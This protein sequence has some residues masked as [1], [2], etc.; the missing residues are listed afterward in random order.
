MKSNNKIMQ[1]NIIKMGNKKVGDNQPVFIIAEAGVNHN[2]SLKFAKK[3][4]DAAKESG[5]DAIKFQTYKTEELVIENAPMAVYQKRTAFGKS[6][7]QMLKQ[8]ELSEADFRELFNYCKKKKIIFLS[9]PFDLQSADFLF[10]L[11]VLAFKISSGDLTNIPLLNHIAK[12]G[13]PMIISTGMSTLAEVRDAVRAVNSTGNKKL[14][15]LHC[16]SNYPTMFEDVNSKA[17]V[18]LRKVFNVPVGY[19]DHT[20]GIEVCMSAVTMGACIIEKHVTL[21]KNLLG[22]DHKASL[23]LEELKKMV[24]CIRNIE[25]ARGSGVKEPR[26]SEIEIKKIVRKSITART[27][28][29][30]GVKITF[31]MLT[32]KRPGTGIR[33]KYLLEIVGKKAKTNIN[34]DSILTWKNL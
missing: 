30:K 15:L 33:P 3:M 6:Q 23:D 21:N 1:K 32:I 17:I 9:T 29:P 2:G 12:Y 27:Y 22:P 25:K 7:F 13:K 26:K 5:A 14:I 24:Q 8:L 28:I 4:I 34:N 11:G 18:T 31:D 10:K 16:T 19:S 20:E